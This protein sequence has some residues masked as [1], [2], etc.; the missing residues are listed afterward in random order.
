MTMQITYSPWHV[1]HDNRDYIGLS[2]YLASGTVLVLDRTDGKSLQAEMLALFRG[3]LP[4]TSLSR[5]H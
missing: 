2:L 5:I 1:A 4:R 3:R